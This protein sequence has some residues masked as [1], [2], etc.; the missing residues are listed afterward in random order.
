[1]NYAIVGLDPEDA[2]SIAT[3]ALFQTKKAAMEEIDRAVDQEGG[4]SM[5][6]VLWDLKKNKAVHKWPVDYPV[7]ERIDFV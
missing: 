2:S 1:M 5:E 4:F 7:E 3:V 6:F